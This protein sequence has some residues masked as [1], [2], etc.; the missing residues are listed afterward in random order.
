MAGKCAST[1]DCSQGAAEMLEAAVEA[2]ASGTELAA[3]TEVAQLQLQH[4]CALW[5]L[6]SGASDAAPSRCLLGSC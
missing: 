4:G 5:T 2:A 3:D 1:A 6:A